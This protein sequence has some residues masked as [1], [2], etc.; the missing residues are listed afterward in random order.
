MPGFSYKAIGRDGVEVSGSEQAETVEALAASLR[1]QQLTLLEARPEKSRTVPVGTVFPFISELSPLLNS[2]IPLERALQIVAEDTRNEKVGGLAEQ[3]RKSI[4]RGG[5]FSGALEQAGRFDVLM[6]ALVRV[7]EASGEL[8]KVLEILEEHYQEVR[9]TRRELLAALTYP[10]ILALV[11]LLSVIGLA[12]YVVPVFKDIFEEESGRA[13]PWGTRFLFTASDFMVAYGW[14]LGLSALVAVVLAVLLVRRV[15]AVNRAWDRLMLS[16]PLFGELQAKFAAF[17]LAKA[18]SIMLSGGLPLAQ[19]VEITRPML[20]NRLQREGVEECI[21]ALRKGEPIPQAMDRIPALPPQFHRYVKLGNETGS[22][23]PNLSKVADMLQ[24][25]FRNGL[26]ALVA[27][28]DPLIIITMGGVV[29]FMVIS[30]LLAVLNL[31]D[32]R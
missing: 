1:R 13:L 5:S 15:D 19:A 30:I 24:D 10:A 6:M 27:V 18:L 28:L 21:R 22:L 29:G 8:P 2:G 17:K 25:D 14:L 4:K 32:V 11:S 31:S 26:R 23:G 20:T 3:L 7:G 16:F 12:L 9:Q